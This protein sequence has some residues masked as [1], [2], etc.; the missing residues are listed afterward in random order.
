ME[1]S[2]DLIICNH[3]DELVSRATYK[4]HN[5]KRQVELHVS[6]LLTK[7]R[8]TQP[9]T[10]SDSDADIDGAIDSDTVRHFRLC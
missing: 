5:R 1:D 2:K 4:R 8:N 7:S 10:D 3:C 9:D 6:S